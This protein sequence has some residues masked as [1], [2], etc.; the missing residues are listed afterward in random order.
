MPDNRYNILFGNDDDL[1]I[2]HFLVT[3]Q[4]IQD[5][6]KKNEIVYDIFSVTNPI[7]YGDSDK[8]EFMHNG[9]FDEKIRGHSKTDIHPEWALIIVDIILYINFQVNKA[10]VIKALKKFKTEKRPSLS[11]NLLIKELVNAFYELYEVTGTRITETSSWD[12][13]HD[14]KLNPNILENLFGKLS[15]VGFPTINNLNPQV[16]RPNT[17]WSNYHD[18]GDEIYSLLQKYGSMSGEKQTSYKMDEYIINMSTS[19]S[20]EEGSTDFWIDDGVSVNKY[21]R[22]INGKLYR[23]INGNKE[24]IDNTTYSIALQNRC[25]SV[26]I[27]GTK[28]S[29]TECTKYITQ[30]LIGENFKECQK[31][32][33]NTT[34]LTF[35]PEE[36]QNMPPQLIEKTIIALNI[37]KKSVMDPIL[38][39]MIDTLVGYDEW[40]NDLRKKLDNN[41]ID[42]IRKH[43][44][45]TRYIQLLISFVNREPAI[46]NPNYIND[47]NMETKRINPKIFEGTYL[48]KIGLKPNYPQNYDYETEII[49]LSDIERLHN[50]ILEERMKFNNDQSGGALDFNEMYNNPPKRMSNLFRDY[51]VRLHKM[52]QN[53]NKQITKSDQETIGKLLNSLEHSEKNLLKAFNYINEYNKLYNIFGERPNIK[54]L[55]FDYLK[56]FVNERNVKSAKLVTKQLNISSMFRALAEAANSP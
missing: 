36:I 24:Y 42:K 2:D 11:L 13:I 23:E 19:K 29:K 45:L 48:Y 1:R 44:T 30:C 39:I 54:N 51:Y 46:L 53:K 40:I 50:M 33:N 3:V 6:V 8:N 18:F 12:K 38:G 14:Y 26:G 15:K 22:D 28:H 43:H 10:D 25:K 20:I 47:N 17:T 31:Y 49:T 7:F 4:H 56:K 32:L 9:L 41:E 35:I 52:L 37:R 27:D 21:F 55:K 16:T 5:K 34:A